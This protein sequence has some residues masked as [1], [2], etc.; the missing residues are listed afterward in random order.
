MSD[1]TTERSDGILRVELPLQQPDA[2]SR[3]VPVE[4]ESR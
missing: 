1:I 3:S 2:R 4:I